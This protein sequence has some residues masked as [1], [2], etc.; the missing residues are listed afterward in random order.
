MDKEVSALPKLDLDDVRDRVYAKY[1]VTYSDAQLAVEYLRCLFDAKRERPNELIILPQIADWAWHE[2]ILDTARYRSVCSQVLGRFLHHVIKSAVDSDEIVLDADVDARNIRELLDP[3]YALPRAGLQASNLREHF[4]KSL[5][6]M[7]NVYGLGLGEHPDQW[8]EAGWDRP[9][10]RLRNPIWIPYHDS[11]GKDAGNANDPEGWKPIRS[12]SWLPGRIARRFGVSVDLARRGVKEYSELFFSLG[13]S[14]TS[15]TLDGCSI[16]CEI[17]WEEHIL[18][19][20]RYTE[21]CQNVFGYFLD[22]V[23]RSSF[24]I[25]GSRA[26]QVA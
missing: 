3:V 2:L 22:H 19:T 11:P 9:T 1:D 23:P 20:Q 26:A 13:S 21:D 25:L 8:L 17:A 16:L 10:Y 24:S 18:W 7:R 14:C 15:N 6:M 5:A 12:L 4:L